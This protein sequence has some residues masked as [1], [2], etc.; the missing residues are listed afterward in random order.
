VR[1]VR[2]LEAARG[3]SADARAVSDWTGFVGAQLGLTPERVERIRL[4]AFLHDTTTPAGD[5]DERA[6]LS[7]RVAATALDAEA[8]GWLL[9]SRPGADPSEL[10]LEAR[11]IAVASAF[12]G[13]GGHRPGAAA[14][15]ALADL[16]PRAGRELDTH[17]VRALEAVLVERAD[18]DAAA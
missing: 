4:A 7:A 11:I 15:A 17:C 10:P 6:R 18:A 5:P 8:A 13:L 12:V 2:T 9:A 14:G 3:H 16:W 1:T